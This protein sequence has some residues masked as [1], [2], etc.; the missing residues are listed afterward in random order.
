[1]LSDYP[2]VK[3]FIVY[4]TPSYVLLLRGYDCC[5]GHYLRSTV[6]RVMVQTGDV[7]TI[8]IMIPPFH[9]TSFAFLPSQ[10]ILAMY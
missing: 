8:R 5:G 6:A 3:S 7:P 9:E 1:M 10:E 4:E 2:L